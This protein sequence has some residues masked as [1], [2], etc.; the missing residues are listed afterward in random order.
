MRSSLDK[1]YQSLEKDI[2]KSF[3]ARKRLFIGLLSG[4]SI[5]IVLA[6]AL[7]WVIPIIGLQNIHPWAPWLLGLF[8]LSLIIL[9]LW[10]SLALVLN[11]QFKTPLLFS[12]KIRGVSIKIF[13]P[14]MIA[15]GRLFGI[16]KEKVRASFI[17]VNNEIVRNEGSRYSPQ[18]ILLLMPHCLQNSR[19]R[20][21][22]TY[23]IYNCKRCG[24]CPIAG[25]L[26]LS[27]TYRIKLA[28]ATGGTIARRIVVQNRPRLILA[29]ACERDLAAGIQDTYPLPVFGI[30]NERPYGP[31]L[32]TQVRLEHL[33]WAIELFIQPEFSK[34]AQ[35]SKSQECLQHAQQA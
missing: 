19:C 14:L 23:N 3:S 7:L 33:K 29:V 32:D 30:L 4:T 12:R 17:R 24:E 35:E 9:V 22:L 15:V 16:S 18:E 31:C 2:Q 5:L 21:R 20:H 10:S 28:I 8:F 6:L 1:A 11:I 25:L 34:A 27:E 26:E 13:L